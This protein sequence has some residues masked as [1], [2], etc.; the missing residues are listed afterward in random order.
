MYIYEILLR[1]RTDTYNDVC[2]VIVYV[3]NSKDKESKGKVHYCK[4]KNVYLR[5]IFSN[6]KK[7]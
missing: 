7:T 6:G 3:H 2:I 5:Y 1:Y 4:R